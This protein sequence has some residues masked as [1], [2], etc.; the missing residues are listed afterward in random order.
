M[1]KIDSYGIL[2]LEG[3]RQRVRASIESIDGGKFRVYEGRGGLKK[4][5]DRVKARG[6]KRLA[7]KGDPR[8]MRYRV[9]AD[10]I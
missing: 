1:S 4:L 3:I 5:A 6:R 9:T 7:Q 2:S 10:A 8:I